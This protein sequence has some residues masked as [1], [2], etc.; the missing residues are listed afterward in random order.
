MFLSHILI[1]TLSPHPHSPQIEK[2]AC[3][4]WSK[5]NYPFTAS[6]IHLEFQVVNKYTCIIF[7]EHNPEIQ[8][9]WNQ[10]GLHWKWWI[11]HLYL[12]PLHIKIQL[13]WQWE[14]TTTMQEKM[15]TQS[16]VQMLTLMMSH[17]HTHTHTHTPRGD[18]K[19]FFFFTH[20]MIHSE[21]IKVAP[22]WFE[23]GLRGRK[24][25]QPLSFY[26]GVGVGL[27]QGFC[28]WFELHPSGKE[29]STQVFSPTCPDLGR[30]ERGKI[31]A[32]KLSGKT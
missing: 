4:H 25:R 19:I 22:K 27:S 24:R 14:T 26:Y 13:K 18:E 3:S 28:T 6:L 8:S 21:E 31:E 17:M 1:W 9:Q 11:G 7:S 15:E 16:L 12:S 5:Y 32:Y 20:I 2:T 30:R 23:N 29:R 10:E